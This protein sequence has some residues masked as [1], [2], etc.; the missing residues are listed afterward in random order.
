MNIINKNRKIPPIIRYNLYFDIHD[1]FVGS[2]GIIFPLWSIGLIGINFPLWSIGL[3][4]IIFPLWSIGLIG[5]GFTKQEG[6]L[7]TWLQ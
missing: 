3:I 5:I 7:G 6:L 4:G 2:I 1:S